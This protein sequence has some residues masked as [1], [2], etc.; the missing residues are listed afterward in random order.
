M[1]KT[2]ITERLT[3]KS[4]I[5]CNGSEM[6]RMIWVTPSK[7]LLSLFRNN[8]FLNLQLSALDC[9]GVTIFSKHR[10]SNS[11]FVK[12]ADNVNVLDENLVQRGFTAA[13][14]EVRMR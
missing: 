14:I 7:L 9:N 13:T 2:P 1:G 10:I 3:N 6:H 12:F 11:K 8:Q 4:F 5:I